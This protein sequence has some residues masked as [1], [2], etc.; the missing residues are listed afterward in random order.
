MPVRYDHLTR[1]DNVFVASRDQ[2]LHTQYHFRP[3]QI[4]M[5]SLEAD[6]ETRTHDSQNE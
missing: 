3:I 1:L 4:S 2:L 6:D 5:T